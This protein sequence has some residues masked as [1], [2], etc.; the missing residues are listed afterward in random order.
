METS[1]GQSNLRLKAWKQTRWEWVAGKLGLLSEYKMRAYCEQSETKILGTNRQRSD[2]KMAILLGLNWRKAVNRF[3][4]NCEKTCNQLEWN[5]R[6]LLTVWEQ[7]KA[8]LETMKKLLNAWK[9]TETKLGTSWNN[10]K[11]NDINLGTKL[12]KTLVT[13]QEQINKTGNKV[14]HFFTAIW[15][16]AWSW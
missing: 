4:V 8:C 14:R 10:V 7:S 3:G 1:K 5:G 2:A 12:E 6:K 9:E 11:R 15:R 16:V 13:V